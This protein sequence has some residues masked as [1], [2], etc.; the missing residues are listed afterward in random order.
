[1]RVSIRR[2]AP[3]PKTERQ[4]GV[5]RHLVRFD[6]EDHLRH[7]VATLLVRLP[8]HRNVQIAHGPLE[9]GKDVIFSVPGG[10]GNTEYCACIIKNTPIT[11][12]HTKKDRISDVLSQVKQAFGSPFLD[13]NAR[14]AFISKCFI[15]VPDWEG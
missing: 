3:G 12:D 5:R 1:M 2:K 7:T 13:A 11:A 10:F 15:I 6:S 14:D 4:D 9:K 8:N